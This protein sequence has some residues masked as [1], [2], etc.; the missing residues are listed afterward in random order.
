M[1]GRAIT[2]YERDLLSFLPTDEYRLFL[3][4]RPERRVTFSRDVHKEHFAM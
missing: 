4:F 3:R 2:S 1:D